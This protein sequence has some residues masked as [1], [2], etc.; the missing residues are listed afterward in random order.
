VAIKPKINMG[1]IIMELKKIGAALLLT[2]ALLFP[3]S[4]V[5][6]SYA[7]DEGANDS[8]SG[9][10]SGSGEFLDTT[11]D[12]VDD[13]KTANT[14][15][16][17]KAQEV[18]NLGDTSSNSLSGAKSPF[19]R[20]KGQKPEENSGRQQSNDGAPAFST[21][22]DNSGGTVPQVNSTSV[23]ADKMTAWNFLTNGITNKNREEIEKAADLYG[24]LVFSSSRQDG[25]FLYFLG[26]CFEELSYL[27]EGGDKTKMLTDANKLFKESAERLKSAPD[28]TKCVSYKDA[29]D[30]S[31]TVTPESAGSGGETAGDASGGGFGGIKPVEHVVTSEFGMRN[32]PVSGGRKMHKG[33]DFSCPKG[34]RPKAINN[35]KVVQ[36]GWV[37][38]YGNTN[39][40]EH[41][42][43]GKK[44][45]T[46]YAHL[47]T[48]AKVGTSVTRGQAVPGMTTGNTGIGTGPHLHFEVRVGDQWG[49]AVNPRR[50]FGVFTK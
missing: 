3:P 4:F 6:R 44:Y 1:G 2:G 9:A 25:K 34:A 43:G 39:V 18:E 36:A 29:V 33:I 27:A 19:D 12:L 10:P 46:R 17:F 32:H 30:K 7:Q 35:G 23:A 47:T 13:S 38:G 5:D 42:V 11:S 26:R 8:S 24:K 49:E 14:S 20:F 15:S 21:N 48:T 40:I 41:T 50:Y 16:S 37:S 45:Y 22:A 28:S 31:E